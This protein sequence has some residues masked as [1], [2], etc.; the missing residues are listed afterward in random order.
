MTD[1]SCI[2]V[3]DFV[4]SPKRL[5]T[6]DLFSN[7]KIVEVRHPK[8]LDESII[9][10]VDKY[11]PRQPWQKNIHKKVAKEFQISNSLASKVLTI[12]I[13][14]GKY[15]TQENGEIKNE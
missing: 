7:R 10:A 4:K 14:R 15:A 12:L 2:L 13:E 11:L 1:A 9:L 5:T 3:F 8:I 6:S